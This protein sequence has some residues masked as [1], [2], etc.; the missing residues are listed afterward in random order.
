L[1]FEAI[2]TIKDAESKAM[3][4]VSEARKKAVQILKDG[5]EKA[6]SIIEE[7]RARAEQQSR[8]MVEEAKKSC[9]REV[10]MLKEEYGKKRASIERI[11]MGN[12]EYYDGKCDINGQPAK[13]RYRFPMHPPVILRNIHCANSDGQF[14]YIWR[15][16]KRNQQ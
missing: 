1:A 5:N 13:A 14:F 3:E 16:K 12:I 6:N 7:A 4:L 11:A 15:N 10:D 2:M 9:E 8:V